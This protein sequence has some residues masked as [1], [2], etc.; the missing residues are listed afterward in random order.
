MKEL[1]KLIVENVDIKEIVDRYLQ[2][3]KKTGNNYFYFTP[4]K[5][6]RTPSFC[7]NSA[8]RIFSCFATNVSGDVIKFVSLMEKIS[9]EDALIKL[10]NEFYPEK[11][12]KYIN[13]DKDAEY[14][15]ITSVLSKYVELC[16]DNFKKNRVAQNYI[17]N[18]RKLSSRLTDMFKIGY[19][20]QSVVNKFSE[21][22]LNILNSLAIIQNRNDT[23][24][25]FTNAIV[26]PTFDNN[27]N[28]VRINHR[29]LNFNNSRSSKYVISK[30]NNYSKDAV[31][32]Y[33][34]VKY[35][36]LRDR[37][38][39]ITEGDFDAMTLI[40][41]GFPAISIKGVNNNVPT[42]MID[43]K[44]HII[45]AFDNDDAGI[46]SAIDNGIKIMSDGYLVS[47]LST[48]P[49]KDISEMHAEISI[50]ETIVRKS[51]MFF[52]DFYYK[53]IKKNTN[54]EKE[55]IY[56]R[57]KIRSNE[58][59]YLKDY[60][61]ACIDYLDKLNSNDSNP[62]YNKVLQSYA[63][64]F[65]FKN[66]QNENID[67][68]EHTLMSIICSNIDKIQNKEIR[69]S[70]ISLLLIMR[71]YNDDDRNAIIG[72]LLNINEYP[73]NI[74]A[75]YYKSEAET[76]DVNSLSVDIKNIFAK[77]YYISENKIKDTINAGNPYSYE[78]V[79]Q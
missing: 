22:E 66:N 35:M 47:V 15:F 61:N 40:D 6:E 71:G 56:F 10:A 64:S 4:F 57:E 34:H 21:N 24:V 45:L 25:P 17:H 67:S 68:I 9:Y 75:K 76:N 16:H 14:D 36:M 46:K 77:Y 29:I 38:L 49:Y 74:I 13:K 51:T 52:L 43:R 58:L 78:E 72:Y 62:D 8:K 19:T 59:N 65:D 79:T 27:G 28:V 2:V 3:Q 5:H 41:I 32:G 1:K 26:I 48:K 12:A 69:R 55:Y 39:Y 20:Y 7:V 70:F 50:N 73:A 60:H 11:V 33:Y 18:Q 30:H 42:K 23:F 37:Q 54:F 53:Q 63:A 44:T 31:F